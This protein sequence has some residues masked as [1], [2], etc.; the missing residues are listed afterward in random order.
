VVFTTKIL[1]SISNI[2]TDRLNFINLVKLQVYK[3]FCF[4]KNSR[5]MI[6]IAG[7]DTEDTFLLILY[8]NNLL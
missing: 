2:D 8:V 5:N 3:P 6:F 7:L 1:F 4:K